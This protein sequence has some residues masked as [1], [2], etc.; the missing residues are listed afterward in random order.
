MFTY[1]NLL[2]NVW[3]KECKTE[4]SLIY[5][6]SICSHDG[7]CFP[8]LEDDWRFDGQD[9]SSAPICPT[10]FDLVLQQN[11]VKH[12]K[13]TNFN[14]LPAGQYY[15]SFHL[16]M[17]NYSC[18]KILCNIMVA[19]ED[20][21]FTPR[22]TIKAPQLR[23]LL[24]KGSKGAAWSC[25][26]TPLLKVYHCQR[27]P[28]AGT[29][30]DI[31]YRFIQLMHVATVHF[32]S[33]QFSIHFISW[34]LDKTHNLCLAHFPWIVVCHSLPLLDVGTELAHEAIEDISERH[35]LVDTI[36]AHNSEPSWHSGHMLGTCWAHP[37]LQVF[38]NYEYLKHLVV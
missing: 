9:L 36:P 16:G 18:K 4:Y 26:A 23:P 11:M 33:F 19:N 14:N 6:V 38:A 8:T 35:Q 1:V 31:Q 37:S 29:D 32:R 21:I 2:C 5:L 10:A 22:M 12:G 28:V 20:E 34:C 30:Q 24:N 27:H 3:P 25:L 7:S 15:F 17:N 13:T